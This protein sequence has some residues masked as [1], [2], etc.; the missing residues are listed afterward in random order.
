MKK[1]TLKGLSSVL[2]NKEMKNVLGGSVDPS[3]C[4]L[5]CG[6]VNMPMGFGP[7]ALGQCLTAAML[8]CQNYHPFQCLNC[9]GDGWW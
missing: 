5:I 7:L 6:S 8:T 3:I 2:S 9:D 4:T 1:I